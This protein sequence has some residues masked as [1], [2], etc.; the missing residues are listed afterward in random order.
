MKVQIKRLSELKDEY[1]KSKDNI[2]TLEEIKKEM[3]GILAYMA[4]LYGHIKRYKGSNH[5]FMEEERKLLKAR[6]VSEMVQA[7]ISFNKATDMCYNEEEYKEHMKVINMVKERFIAYEEIYSI[8]QQVLQ[9]VIQS[10]SVLNK[11]KTNY[12]GE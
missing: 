8:Y 11:E 10:I 9:S 5:T 4:T 6:V 2:L 12:A 3:V 1:I 7:G